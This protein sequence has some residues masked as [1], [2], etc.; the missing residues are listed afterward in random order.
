MPLLV[1]ICLGLEL[2][3]YLEAMLIKCVWYEV[4]QFC[5]LPN[6]VLGV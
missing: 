6:K 1:V 3:A 2:S 4:Y 5:R